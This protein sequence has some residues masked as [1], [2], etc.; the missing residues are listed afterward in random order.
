MSGPGTGPYVLWGDTSMT[1]S[2]RALRALVLLAGFHLM[3]VVLLAALIAA[4]WLLLTRLFVA[5]AVYLVLSLVLTSVALMVPILRGMFAFLLAGRRSSAPGGHP[6]TPQEQPELW[7]EVLEAARSAGTHA[8]DEVILTEEV[9]ASVSERARLLGLL[10]GRRGMYLGVPLLT[11]LTVPRLRAVLAHEFGHYSNQDARLA[12][13]TMRGRAAVLHTVDAFRSSDSRAHAFVG[14]LYVRYARFFLKVSQSVARRQEFAADRAAARHVGRN[15]TAAA[16]RQIPLLHAAHDHYVDTYALMGGPASALPPVGE[17]HGG[18][19]HLLAA[20]QPE[21]LAEL[22]AARRPPRP[23]PYDSHP[24][25]HERVALIEALP[26][27]GPPDDPAAPSA[28]SLLRDQDAVLVTL[29]TY[30]LPAVASTMRRLDWPDLV[31]LRAVIDARGWAEPLQKALRRA[32]RTAPA[33]A[34]TSASVT[35]AGAAATDNGT[36]TKTDPGEPGLEAVLDAV[37]DGLLWMAIA[38]R[39][40]KHALAARLTGQSARTFIRPAVWDAVAGLVHLHLIAEGLARPDIS[41]PG[42]PGLTLP[43]EWEEQM[44][45]A[46]D[47][48]V[49]DTPDTTALRALLGPE[50]PRCSRC[51]GTSR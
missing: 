30:T 46:I 17:F 42:Q 16:L 14:G 5:Q 38:D 26:D 35:P 41:W 20:R 47:A 32:L 4:D 18:F 48:A 36:A 37:D 24:P 23:S 49:A 34:S 1:A 10:P 27:D 25:T 2:L 29:E 31:I 39:M 45:A 15:A 44:D 22:A 6:V 28:L 8:P 3:G 33:P 51:R 7:A 9:N 12:G 11:G 21:A 50:Q 40:P 43:E 19:R 13:V